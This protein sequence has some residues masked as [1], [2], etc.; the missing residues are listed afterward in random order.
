MFLGQLLLVIAFLL[1]EVVLPLESSILAAGVGCVMPEFRFNL[2]PYIARGLLLV[3]VTTLV[4]FF[5]GG[6][7]SEKIAYANK[8]VAIQQSISDS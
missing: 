2:H 1:T 7:Y 5:A 3:S 6:M 4:L 8:Y